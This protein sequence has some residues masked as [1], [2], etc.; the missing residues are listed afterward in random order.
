LPE[1]RRSWALRRIPRYR[2]EGIE[3]LID[4][5][6]PREAEVSIVESLDNM[7]ASSR[8]GLVPTVS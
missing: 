3:V 5:R 2:E 8:S 4:V 6:T 1:N 7:P